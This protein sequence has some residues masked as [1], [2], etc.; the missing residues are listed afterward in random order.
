MLPSHY[1]SSSL[2]P[3]SALP[4]FLLRI[5]FIDRPSRSFK[6]VEIWHDNSNSNLNKPQY[7]LLLLGSNL[8][9]R[10]GLLSRPDLSWLEDLATLLGPYIVDVLIGRYFS[11]INLLRAEGTY[12]YREIIPIE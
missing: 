11:H 1:H 4:H 9:Q 8:T 10:L 6:Y 7:L 5:P 12:S 3:S 2:I